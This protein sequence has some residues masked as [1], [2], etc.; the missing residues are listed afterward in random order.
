[1][2]DCKVCKSKKY[3][4]YAETLLGF[5]YELCRNITNNAKSRGIE[6]K[7]EREDVI[8][9]IQIFHGKCALTGYHLTYGRDD[10]HVDN[11]YNVSVDRIDSSKD[12]TTDNIQPVCWIINKMKSYL[13]MDQLGDLC[14]KVDQYNSEITDISQQVVTKPLIPEQL[15]NAPVIPVGF[16]LEKFS[17][18]GRIIRNKPRPRHVNITV[19]FLNKLGVKI[20]PEFRHPSLPN[21][22]YKFMFE[23]NGS[24]YLIDFDT[25]EYFKCN[26]KVH[27]TIKAFLEKQRIIALKISVALETGYKLIR[28][29]Y[30]QFKN[31]TQHLENALV[32]TGPYYLSTCSMYEW[33]STVQY[34]TEFLTQ[35]GV[36]LPN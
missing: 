22:L 15:I 28:I 2:P 21:R 34:S 16:K 26:L 10:E 25:D 4:R 20:I 3:K 11:I 17:P 35:E 9:L 6:S 14:L 33:V 24:K 1:M 32:D 29:D 13:T 18:E 27:K 19:A 30:T 36:I 5:I 31:V 12:Y 8:R 23:Y 7:L